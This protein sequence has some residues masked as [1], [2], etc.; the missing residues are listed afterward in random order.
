[1]SFPRQATE[2][3]EKTHQRY[4]PKDKVVKRPGKEPKDHVPKDED[5]KDQVHVFL[6][7]GVAH[8]HATY[9]THSQDHMIRALT[10]DKYNINIAITSRSNRALATA[11]SLR[12]AWANK[13]PSYIVVVLVVINFKLLDVT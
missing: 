12:A 4:C 1:M 10:R 6:M 7:G 3:K 2:E 9:N 13:S 5:L 11:S 8:A